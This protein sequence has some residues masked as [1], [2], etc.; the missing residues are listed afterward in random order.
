MIVGIVLVV[1]VLF[2]LASVKPPSSTGSVVYFLGR[3]VWALQRFVH[4]GAEDAFSILHTKAALVRENEELRAQI[5]ELEWSMLDFDRVRGE[6]KKYES[7]L[8]R[9]TDPEFVLGMVLAKPGALPYDT[10]ILDVG[11]EN[12]ISVGDTVLVGS[13]IAVGKVIDV[14][15]SISK[16]QFFSSSGI[17]TPVLVGEKARAFDAHGYGAG[18][19]VINVPRDLE[20]ALGEPVYLPT[21]PRTF[22]GKV[23][24]VN[25]SP[26]DAMKVVGIRLPVNLFEISHV[27]ILHGQPASEA[28]FNIEPQ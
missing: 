24:I 12:G 20:I 4:G 18:G 2:S 9:S 11:E 19:M 27:K 15:S 28:L 10:F 23:E 6:L 25:V 22:I 7:V 21:D 1:L 3:P 14:R 26:S 8:G 16:V 13:D 17:T 5:K